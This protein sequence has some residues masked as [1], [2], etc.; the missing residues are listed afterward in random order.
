MFHIYLQSGVAH[1]HEH[2]GLAPAQWCCAA[3]T[4]SIWFL[5][6]G[7]CPERL[8]RA[9]CRFALRYLR[10]GGFSRGGGITRASRRV[11]A[12][13]GLGWKSRLL[14]S[15]RLQCNQV[16]VVGQQIWLEISK[17]IERRSLIPEIDQCCCR[18]SG[19]V[20]RLGPPLKLK[21]PGW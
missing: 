17:G 9:P 11:G 7:G 18:R 19:E 15:L 6:K 20:E 21:T 4:S 1:A 13:A 12:Q 16:R 5:R 2:R 8:W 10:C 14:R 3:H